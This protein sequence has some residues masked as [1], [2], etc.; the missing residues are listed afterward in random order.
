MAED[1]EPLTPKSDGRL[2]FMLAGAALVLLVMLVAERS[3][4]AGT[5]AEISD[6]ESKLCE[7]K[8]ALRA[9]GRLFFPW[10][11]RV[12]DRTL[13]AGKSLRSVVKE[14]SGAAGIGGNLV[15]I[16]PG[17]DRKKGM[18]HARVMLRGVP[19]NKITEFILNLR[20]LG[21]GIRDVEANLTMMGYNA[22]RWQMDVMLEAP[23][24]QGISPIKMEKAD[25]RAN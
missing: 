14:A 9:N 7:A 13:L 2:F 5:L 22:D 6:M 12:T 19:L 3:A 18:V 1:R 23:K 8:N 10:T 25:A 17:E 21:A 11:E 15:S 20:N 16:T 24:P 4:R